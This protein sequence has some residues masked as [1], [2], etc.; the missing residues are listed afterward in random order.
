[1][2]QA[3]AHARLAVSAWAGRVLAAAVEP[4]TGPVAWA[5]DVARVEEAAKDDRRV[6][7]VAQSG[8]VALGG[9]GPRRVG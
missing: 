4:A 1:M 6:W 5:D 2:V 9:R 3:V 8:A 7:G